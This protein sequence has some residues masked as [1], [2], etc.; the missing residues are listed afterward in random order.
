[1]IAKYQ[2][3]CERCLGLTFPGQEIEPCPGVFGRWQHVVMGDCRNAY[4]AK[5]SAQIQS[6][7]RR[8]YITPAQVYAITSRDD[9]ATKFP[10]EPREE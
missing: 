3:K 10:D 6:D 1:M 5:Q 4:R 2:G 9:A 7:L 8:G